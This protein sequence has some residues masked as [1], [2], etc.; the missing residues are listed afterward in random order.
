[1][2][3]LKQLALQDT[4]PNLQLIQPRGVGW[5]PTDFDGDGLCSAGG[6][7]CQPGLQPLGRMG[8]PVIQNQ[9]QGL[10]VACSGSRQND[11]LQEG[12]KIHKA[13]ATG[14]LAEDLSIG[15]TQPSKQMERSLPL[16]AWGLPHR[17]PSTGRLWWA[18]GG[19]G[20][21]RGLLLQADQP[22]A[23]F[24]QGL[25]LGVAL[26]DRTRSHQKLHR[27][28]DVLPGM[29]AP[30]PQPL[31]C[32]PPPNGAGGDS[33]D[34]VGLLQALGD[35]SAAPP[36]QRHALSLGQATGYRRRLSADGWGKNGV[37]RQGEG[38]RQ[39]SA[40][41]ASGDATC[42]P[43]GPS[44][45]RPEQSVDW[46]SQDAHER[47]TQS[48]RGLPAR[49]DWCAPVPVVARSEV[50]DRLR[51]WASAAWVHASAAPPLPSVPQTAPLVKLG[52]HLRMAVLSVALSFVNARAGSARLPTIAGCTNST[53]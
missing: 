1:M 40:S 17:V 42:A 49:V 35:L 23:C 10:D 19:A 29:I 33:R 22:G 9:S 37:G 43:S 24:Q 6:F 34:C 15:Y 47:P 30:G 39:A 4:Q 21:D 48:G 3:R 25:S 7:G 18:F 36:G 32:Q 31:C 12:L 8:G 11:L 28:V 5:Q 51:R 13:L 27:V 14:A 26:Q 44:E 16:V 38:G 52:M 50:R 41:P 46:T 2:I 45:R 20:L 53:A